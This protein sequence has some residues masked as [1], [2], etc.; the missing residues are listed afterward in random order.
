MKAKFKKIKLTQIDWV[1]FSI[2]EKELLIKKEPQIQ[3]EDFKVLDT[4]SE[5]EILKDL[6]QLDLLD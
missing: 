6:G 3:N 5:Y 1:D 2:D 4:R